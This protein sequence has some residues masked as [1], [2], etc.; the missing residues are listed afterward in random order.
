MIIILKTLDLINEWQ[1]CWLIQKMFGREG[2]GNASM[3]KILRAKES[4]WFS[5]V[6]SEQRKKPVPVA[7]NRFVKVY[8]IDLQKFLSQEKRQHW[9]LQRKVEQ[10]T[11]YVVT[12]SVVRQHGRKYKK[13]QVM[14]TNIVFGINIINKSY[15]ILIQFYQCFFYYWVPLMKA[16]T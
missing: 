6:S 12:K 10:C 16:L 3:I 11:W 1:F 14:L 4:L 2:R 8:S 15:H 13:H 5:D 9:L 7:W